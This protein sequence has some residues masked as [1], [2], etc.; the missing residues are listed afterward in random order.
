MDYFYVYS[1]GEEQYHE[2]SAFSLKFVL[3]C[4]MYLIL[5]VTMNSNLESKRMLLNE[6]YRQE[7][8]FQ[9]NLFPFNSFKFDYK[10]NYF[11]ISKI[12]YEFSYQFNIAKVEYYIAFYDNTDNLI[13]PSDMA[14]YTNLHLM[15]NFKIPNTTLN[16]E[17]MPSIVDDKYHKC[18]EFFQL[19]EKVNFGVKVYLI[20]EKMNSVYFYLFNEE[21]FNFNDETYHNDDYF[22]PNLIKYEHDILLNNFDDMR[23]NETLK[24]KKSFEMYPYCTLKRDAL[25]NEDKWLYRN[26]YNNYFCMCKGEDCLKRNITEKCKFYFYSTI[27]HENR[28]VYPKTEYVF[29][30]FVKAD[31]S[32]DDTYPVFK[33]MLKMG[34]PAIYITGNLDIYKEHC[35][36]DQYCKS[37]LLA[38]KDLKPIYGDFLE[39]NIFMFFKIKVLVSGRPNF[40]TDL[41]YNMEYT[42]YV[43]VGHGICYFKDYLFNPERIYGIRKNDKIIVPDS[44]ILVDIIK[45]HGWKEEDIFRVNLPRWDRLYDMENE[46]L[47]MAEKERNMLIERQK[48]EELQRSLANQTNLLEQNITEQNQTDNIMNLNQTDKIINSNQTENIINQSQTQN[49]QSMQNQIN[50]FSNE[51]Q[52]NQTNDFSNQINQTQQIQINHILDNRTIENNTISLNQNQSNSYQIEQSQNITSQNDTTLQNTNPVYQNITD[53]QTDLYNITNTQSITSD[54]NQTYA[55]ATS[56]ISQENVTDQPTE[57]VEEEKKRTLKTNSIFIMFTWRDIQLKKQI[58]PDYLKNFYNLVSSSSLYHELKIR[59]ITMYLSF[60]RLVEEKY[61]NKF[62]NI[63]KERPLIEFITQQEISECLGRTSLVVTDFSSIV[64][65][66]MYRGKPFIIYVPDGNEPA[67]RQIYK[68]DYYKLIESMKNNTIEFENKY[69]SLYETIEKI[70]FYIQNNFTLDPKLERFYQTFGFKREKMIDKFVDYLLKLN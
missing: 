9:E 21:R 2:K 55:N 30:D 16:I 68:P 43:C 56:N 1:D 11:N 37:V 57:Q 61:V 60:H 46:N 41:F 69:F 50:Q 35:G 34:K 14:F 6:R 32:S 4:F 48:M 10:G 49:M 64:F 3:L 19:N 42:T 25:L 63:V 54:I 20:N 23:I 17:S 65:D 18:V 45:K 39:K 33:A 5:C 52:Q 44:K 70:I 27:I 28:N 66:L 59:N 12:D 15:C 40:S 53:N 8:N 7:F 47:I 24:L 67:L 22:N 13:I 29:M 38:T 62:K 51:N 36:D 58:S 26:L 31:L